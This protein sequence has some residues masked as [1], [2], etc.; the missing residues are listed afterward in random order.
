MKKKV[1]FLVFVLS[2]LF[3]I[4]PLYAS[5]QLKRLGISPFYKAR[6][7]QAEAIYPII[8]QNKGDAE[9][10]FIKAGAVNLF[11]PFITQLKTTKIDAVQVT[12]GETFIWMIFK[13]KKKI[14]VLND[15]KWAGKAPFEGYR[16]IIEHNNRA[17]EFIIPKVCFNIAL[18]SVTDIPVKAPVKTEAE[19]IEPKKEVAEVAEVPKNQSPQCN[20]SVSPERF[21]TGTTVMS[22]ASKSVDSDGKVV[23]V[24][25]TIIDSKGS[26]VEKKVVE[27]APFIYKTKI[28]KSG[29]HKIEAVVKD[30]AGGESPVNSCTREVTVLKRGFFVGDIGL[31]QQFDPATFLPI[32]VGY[33]HKLSEK[34]AI[35]A[36]VGGAPLLNGCSDNPATI[37]DIRFS[38]YPAPRFF[39][40]AGSGMWHTTYKTRT[41]FIL[42]TGYQLTDNPNGPNF[43][44][45]LEGRSAFDEFDDISERGRFGGGLRA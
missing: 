30:D 44:I 41:D 21:L 37:G 25:F 20:L 9:A 27:E 7:L 22:D 28:K 42:D 13:K 34:F 16:F 15:V 12:P 24:T 2:V 36:L 31:L 40:S 10:G 45:Y 19:K 17:Y 1:I 29:V 14:F 18:K 35:T 5:T 38:Y 11:H 43:S 4:H 39:V 8:M 23:S 32:R 3:G 33:M 6:D 26:I